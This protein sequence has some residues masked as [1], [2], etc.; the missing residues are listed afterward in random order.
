MTSTGVGLDSGVL[1]KRFVFRLSV[2]VDLAIICI[3]F[4][5]NIKFVTFFFMSN[6]KYGYVLATKY[7]IVT[8]QL[9]NTVSLI[10][11]KI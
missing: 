7:G 11:Y 2:M 4:T 5:L 3:N 8:F 1:F 9:C 10:S 6:P